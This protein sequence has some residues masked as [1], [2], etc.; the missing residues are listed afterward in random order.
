M[1]YDG[2]IFGVFLLAHALTLSGA[3][4]LVTRKMEYDSD[5]AVSIAFVV[6]F[7]WLSYAGGQWM[8]WVN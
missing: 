6:L 1:W 4:A 3:G 7:G 8:G 5:I 2:L